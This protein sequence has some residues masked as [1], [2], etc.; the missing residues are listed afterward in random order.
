MGCRRHTI[1]G[2]FRRDVRSL[3]LDGSGEGPQLRSETCG[4]DKRRYTR[5]V[6]SSWS[7]GERSGQVS[8]VGERTETSPASNGRRMSVGVGDGHESTDSEY[9]FTNREAA[10]HEGVATRWVRPGAQPIRSDGERDTDGHPRPAKM[11]TTSLELTLA[12]DRT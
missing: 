11:P 9:H 3:S 8:G 4:R 5:R 1:A 12:I 6:V 10:R 2:L 7:T